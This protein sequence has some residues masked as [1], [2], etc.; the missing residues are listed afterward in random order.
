MVEMVLL[1]VLIFLDTN[2][3]SNASPNFVNLI[4]SLSTGT[5]VAIAGKGEITNRL[6]EKAIQA[7]EGLESKYI[8][9]IQYHGS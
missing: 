3:D 2:H 8:R 4:N 7:I 1:L 6:S 9:Q 5:V